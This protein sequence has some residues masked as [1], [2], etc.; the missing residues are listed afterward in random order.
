MPLVWAH[1]EYV[2]LLRSLRDGRVYDM[3]PQT[4]QRYIVAKTE[5]NRVS[6]R[7]DEKRLNM[8]SGKVLRIEVLAMAAVHWS[9]DNWQTVNDTQTKE[10]GLGIYIVDLPVNAQ[11][12]NTSLVFTFHWLANDTWEGVDFSVRIV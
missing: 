10:T 4:V 8:P 2:K 9:V 3:P 12:V 11:P 1:A 6:W 5:S 7:F